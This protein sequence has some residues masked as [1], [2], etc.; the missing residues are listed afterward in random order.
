MP[1]S[2]ALRLLL[3][4]LL[5]T[6]AAW[7]LEGDATVQARAAIAAADAARSA[8]AAEGEAMARERIRAEAAIGLLE[9]QAEAEERAIA[10]LERNL[11]EVETELEEL[12][13]RDAE[14]FAWEAPLSAVHAAAGERL[15]ALAP[16]LPPGVLPPAAT[17]EEGTA[18]ALLD[19]HRRLRAGLDATA[20]WSLGIEE[21]QL[22]G[23]ARAV[24][25]LRAGAVAGWWSELDGPRAGVARFEPTGVVLEAAADDTQR[26]TIRS[27]I[28]IAGGRASPELVD[29][30]LV[31]E[32][33]R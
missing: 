30:P 24:N 1:M 12:A 25:L 28:A 18:Q 2:T 7:S 13:A 6:A 31:P 15:A 16:R 10:A 26:R 9:A 5:T 3:A 21:G 4:T 17:D 27:A 22:D 8:E 11:A 23:E 32:V 29:L 19:L 14:R 20:S 33:G